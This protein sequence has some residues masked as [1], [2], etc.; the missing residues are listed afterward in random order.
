VLGI[1][2]RGQLAQA[3]RIIRRRI[4]SAWMLAGVTIEDPETA[5]IERRVKLG[6]DTVL[7]SYVILEGDTE[8]GPE[9]LIGPYVSIKD[10]RLGKEVTVRSFCDITG[11]QIR[12][13]AIIG[14]FARLRPESVV[15]EE[16]RVGNFVELK[17]TRLGK[18]SKANHLTYLGDA[19]V[20][21]GVNIGAGT[22]TC[23]YDGKH[24]HP[25]VV[26]DD[27]FIG[28]GA[29]LIA[30]VKV[31]KGAYVAAGSTITEDVPPDALAIARKKQ[32][33]KEEWVA[34]KRLTGDS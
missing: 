15:E 3:S 33:N 23:N 31:G 34:K 8:V 1:N 27:V 7:R 9:C 13:R 29:E 6:R 26:E 18:G 4:L 24:K 17:K 32:E 20:G 30:P 11:T 22:I 16:A 28:S 25:T 21:Q 14:P 19:T 12:D 2:D 5:T 10:S